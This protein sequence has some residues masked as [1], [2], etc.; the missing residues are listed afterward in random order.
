ME[1]AFYAMITIGPTI[2]TCMWIFASGCGTFAE[3]VVGSVIFYALLICLGLAIIQAMRVGRA[4]EL[5]KTKELI[6]HID[7]L[8]EQQHYTEA[9]DLIET[10]QSEGVM[11][12]NELAEGKG[13]GEGDLA[14]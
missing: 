11:K 13:S 2:L 14:E 7:N 4:A 12:A 8:L 1:I 6:N 10:Y 3:R 5:E 9:H